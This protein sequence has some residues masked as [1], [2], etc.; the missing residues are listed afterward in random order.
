MIINNILGIILGNVDLLKGQVAHEG[1]VLKRVEAIEHAAERAATLT[2]QLLGF[3]RQQATDVIAIDITRAISNMD[4]LTAITVT[5]EV[6]ISQDFAKGLWLTD[7][8]LGDFQDALLNLIL[9]ARDAMPGGGRITIETRNI[10]LDAAYCS[11]NPTAKVGE[12]VQLSISDTGKGITSEQQER[13]FE[14]FYTTKPVGKGTGLGLAMVF[15]FIERSDGHIKVYSEPGI[16]T[17]LHLYLPRS[18]EQE[19]A[20]GGVD[21][22]LKKLPL[23]HETIL[24]VDDEP[25]LL[26]LAEDLLLS[27]GYRVLTASNGQQALE[28]LVEEPDIVLLF[29]DVVM[30]GG[31]NGY[32]LA[33]KAASKKPGLKVLLTSGY[34]KKAIAQNGQA[35]FDANLLGKPYTQSDLALRVR[36]L[37][38][39][40]Q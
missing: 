33:E 24:V 37:L 40:S 25:G 16:G 35:R 31:I 13:I 11:R 8:N 19:E 10:T 26:E 1:K 20:I 17:T 23:G 36:S 21:Q 5:P 38:D 12:Y 22:H 6:E 28:R 39:E 2:K 15:G 7:I 9:N 27:L 18:K 14:P 3:S 34:T 30:P 4:S 32:E 29:S